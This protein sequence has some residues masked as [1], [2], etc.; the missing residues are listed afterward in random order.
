MGKTT[1]KIKI[2]KTTR[3]KTKRK[4]KKQTKKQIQKRIIKGDDTD[5]KQSKYSY[6]DFVACDALSCS[7]WFAT[8]KAPKRALEK[9]VILAK[10]C[11]DLGQVWIIVIQIGHLL[12]QLL[13]KDIIM[14]NQ[15]WWCTGAKWNGCIASKCEILSIFIII[16]AQFCP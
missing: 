8:W 13:I 6:K 9:K 16:M 3:I 5:S 7:N 4:I 2:I 1:K 11:R 10:G 15:K 14:N 12:V